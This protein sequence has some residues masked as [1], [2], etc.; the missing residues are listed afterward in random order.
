MGLERAPEGCFGYRR[1]K[2]NYKNKRLEELTKFVILN[3]MKINVGS[4]NDVKIKAVE[5]IFAEFSNFQPAKIFGVEVDSEVHKQ[6]KNIEQTMQGAMNR[7]KNA[8]VD[9]DLSVG[10][11]G[12]LVEMSNTKSG[13]MNVT[14]CAIYDGKRFHLGGSSLFELPKSLVDLIFGKKYEMS[15]AAKEAGFAHDTNLGKREG[16]IGVLTKGVLDRKGY[17]KQ[18]VLTAVIQLL[19]PEHY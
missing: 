15:E 11:E 17:S 4:K 16:M 18:A 14:I 8:F 5:E 9:C 10:L 19:N 13:Y 6:P 3:Y 12:G 7:A 1:E 2:Q